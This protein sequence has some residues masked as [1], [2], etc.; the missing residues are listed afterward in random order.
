MTEV[1]SAP[2]RSNGLPLRSELY[3]KALHLVA[4]AVPIG[5][6][7]LGRGIALSILIPLSLAAILADV[8]RWRYAAFHAWID[9]LFGFMMRPSE[10]SYSLSRPIL[11]G[12]TWVLIS[13]TLLALLF[14]IELA[15][16]AFAAFMVGDAAAALVGRTIGK[17]RWGNGPRTI[18]GSAAFIA[19][20]LAVMVP[21][22]P[23]PLWVA[24]TSVV[25]G[26]AF[27]IPTWPVNDNLRVPLL[28][29]LILHLL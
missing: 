10:K 16:A 23:D 9:G 1:P 2:H 11:N 26:A 22:A 13:A 25:A 18:E 15:G 17:H 20:G 27:E 3:R 19:A 24:V 4:L 14:P 12:A 6:L 7:W 5:M 29:T 8:L 28:M 21:L